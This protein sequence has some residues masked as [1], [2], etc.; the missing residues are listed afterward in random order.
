MFVPKTWKGSHQIAFWEFIHGGYELL[1]NYDSPVFT[2]DFLVI[3]TTIRPSNGE[4][5]EPV[6]QGCIVLKIT[7][8][9][10]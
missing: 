5:Y 1:T 9:E 6:Q 8:F 4:V 2:W 7:I 10:E 3:L